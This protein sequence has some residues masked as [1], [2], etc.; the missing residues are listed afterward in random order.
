MYFNK[1]NYYRVISTQTLPENKC[2][3]LNSISGTYNYVEVWQTITFERLVD[4]AVFTEPALRLEGCTVNWLQLPNQT[5]WPEYDRHRAEDHY[6]PISFWL[7]YN[8]S[9]YISHW[10]MCTKNIVIP[11]D[12]DCEFTCR[13]DDNPEAMSVK[14]LEVYT[15]DTTTSTTTS[16]L[17]V[18]YYS[19]SANA[20][21]M[22]V[23]TFHNF[24]HLG[25]KTDMDR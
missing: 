6:I 1:V 4:S 22:N 24:M 12:E 10:C 20:D 13:L 11:E 25:A 8:T 3:R 15:N 16:I 23:T 2:V 5:T 9:D 19:Y 21:L 14:L 17:D 18:K 7:G